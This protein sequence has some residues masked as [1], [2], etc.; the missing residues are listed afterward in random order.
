MPANQRLAHYFFARAR[1]VRAPAVN[2]GRD[3]PRCTIPHVSTGPQLVP[4][5]A[6][7]ERNWLPLILAAAVILA[8]AGGAWF[9]LGRGKTR[10][11]VT[12]INAPPDPYAASLAISNLAMSESSNLAGGKLT[13]LDG[14]IANNGNR[15]VTAISMQ[16]LFRDYTHQVAWN[17]TQP[18]QLIRT[19]EPYVDTVPVSAAPLKPSDHRDFRLIFDGVPDSWDGAYPDLRI[20]HVGLE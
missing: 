14:E 4:P 8:V 6:P 16:V 17:D 10:P 1:P 2:P 12:P 18:L 15:T 5:S 3:S 19:R 11:A 13:Y 20:V 7:A 9:F